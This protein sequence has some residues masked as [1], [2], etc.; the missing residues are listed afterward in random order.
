M[1]VFDFTDAAH[2]VEIAFFD[3]GPLDASTLI[4][5][6][7]WSTYW[8]NGFIYGAEMARGLDV[9]R[10]T[11]SAQLS[12]AELDAASLVQVERFNVQ[13]QDRVTWPAHPTVARA[14]LAQLERGQAL[15]PARVAAVR[16]WLD[17]EPS[18]VG[19]LTTQLRA[20]AAAASG[21]D[22]TRLDA[23]AGTLD[24]IANGR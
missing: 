1:S 8:Y 2:P 20:D 3:R 12:Q 19:T 5:G 18:A 4:T 21:A 6:G 10:L 17:A 15:A 11:A 24:G 23:L 14:Y 13:H 9:L 7:Y 22:A 16:A